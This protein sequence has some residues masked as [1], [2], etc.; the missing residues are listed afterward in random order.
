MKDDD[1]QTYLEEYKRES[2]IRPAQNGIS[3]FYSSC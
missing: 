2:L 3:Y 1:R